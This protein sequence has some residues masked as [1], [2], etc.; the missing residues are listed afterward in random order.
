[1]LQNAHLTIALAATIPETFEPPTH[2]VDTNWS[3][4]TETTHLKF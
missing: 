4:T 2:V 1:M 3:K